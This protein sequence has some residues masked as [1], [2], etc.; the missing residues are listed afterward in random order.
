M[1]IL[2]DLPAQDL[3][4]KLRCTPLHI[5]NLRSSIRK[6]WGIESNQALCQAIGERMPRER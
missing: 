4:K 5:Y 1:G 6:K 3:A 2:N